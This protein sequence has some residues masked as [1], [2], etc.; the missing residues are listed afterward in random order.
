MPRSLPE[1]TLLVVGE[2]KQCNHSQHYLYRITSLLVFRSNI[3][4]KNLI[5]LH[6]TTW[7]INDRFSPPIY[8]FPIGE[9][10][11]PNW[12]NRTSIYI[13]LLFKHY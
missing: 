6:K 7:Y 9:I 4:Q 13:K 10:I 1:I 12:E 11:F 8:F 2:N 3:L 5:I